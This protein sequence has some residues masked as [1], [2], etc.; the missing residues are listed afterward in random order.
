MILGSL[1]VDII[2]I[3]ISA[4]FGGIFT[5]VLVPLLEIALKIGIVVL[6]ALD[7]FRNKDL[8]QPYSDT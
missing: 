2:V 1:L 8:K 7:Y 3:S 6:C 4:H 5:I